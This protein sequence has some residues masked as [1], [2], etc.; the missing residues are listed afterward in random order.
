[1]PIAFYMDEHIPMAITLGLR[2]RGVDI[3]TAQE[4]GKGCQG[5]RNDPNP[6]I[7]FRRR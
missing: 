3:L 2:M 1:M 5:Q 7:E 6:T 4:D